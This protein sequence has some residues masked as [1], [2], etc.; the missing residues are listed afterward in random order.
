MS[1]DHN[2]TGTFVRFMLKSK[3]HR[4]RVT[5]A[6]VDYEGSITLD[7]DLLRAADIVPYEEVHVW[8][9]TRGH[10]LRTYAMVAEAGSGVVCMNGA[11]ALLAKPGDLVIIATFT[12]MDDA[13]ARHFKPRIVLVDE[14]NHIRPIVEEVAGPQRRLNGEP[15]AKSTREGPPLL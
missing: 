11:A 13:A 4:A 12:Q 7:S 5:Q 9:V 14:H 8:N 15:A 10:R 1:A 6:D 2:D 3:I